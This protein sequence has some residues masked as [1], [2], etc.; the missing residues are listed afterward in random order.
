M[1]TETWETHWD[2]WQCFLKHLGMDPHLQRLAYTNRVQ[3]LTGF[4]AYVHTG[5]A[6]WD[7]MVTTQTVTMALMAIDQAIALAVGS[8]PTKLLGSNKLL[9]E[10][11]QIMLDG[12]WKNESASSK[13]QPVD[14]DVPEYS[15]LASSKQLLAT[16][17]SLYFITSYVCVSTCGRA[18]KICQSK[19]CSL[20]WKTSLS[21]NSTRASNT[22]HAMMLQSGLWLTTLL[23]LILT[24]K[25]WVERC[26]HWPRA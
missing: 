7:G 4:A 22:F 11:S 23:S 6:K 10:L 16:L 19:Q 3:V 9:P 21:S 13:I 26:M 12:W 8:N 17:P 5:D 14:A 15:L 18:L 25:K 1:C 24:T 2:K 20:R